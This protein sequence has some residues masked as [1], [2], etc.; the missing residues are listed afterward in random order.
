MNRVV[1]SGGV[2]QNMLLRKLLI[3]ELQA[4]GFDVY[5]NRKVP[6]GDGGL[7]VGQLYCIPTGEVERDLPAGGSRLVYRP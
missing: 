5:F 2:F 1:L 3:P 7:A 4:E 6:P